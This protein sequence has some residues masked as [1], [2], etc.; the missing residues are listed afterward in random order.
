M[1]SNPIFMKSTCVP[2]LPRGCCTII[3]LKKLSWV[4]LVVNKKHV[5]NKGL[6]Q[7]MMTTY[8]I[9]SNLTSYFV[10]TYGR[11]KWLSYKNCKGVN[12]YGKNSQIFKKE[13]KK[14]IIKKVMPWTFSHH[15]SKPQWSYLWLLVWFSTLL[16]TCE[17]KLTWI[18]FL[19]R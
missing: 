11:A 12:Y 5:D 13:K 6:L 17:H 2:F 19:K 1:P 18:E 4:S 16:I 10:A 9:F 7:V 8:L 15:W 3:V 14:K